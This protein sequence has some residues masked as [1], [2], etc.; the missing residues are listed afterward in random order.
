MSTAELVQSR[1]QALAEAELR[2][3]RAAVARLRAK[4]ALEEALA[5]AFR[6]GVIQGKNAEERQAKARELLGA[7]YQALAQ[8]EEEYLLAK[9]EAE[10]AKALAQAAALTAQLERAEPT[11][12]L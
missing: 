3:G 8:A 9:A 12:S 5:E 2:L 7:L 11:L 4:E 1:F 10:A 6:S